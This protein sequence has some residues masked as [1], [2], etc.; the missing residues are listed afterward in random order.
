[1][2]NGVGG[3]LLPHCGRCNWYP[4]IWTV[5][6]AAQQVQGPLPVNL[7]IVWV[8]LITP[9]SSGKEKERNRLQK[10][11]HENEIDVS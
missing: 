7:N 1:M 3:T 11:I 4:K 2:Q 6:T 5:I 9:Q 10:K 8:L